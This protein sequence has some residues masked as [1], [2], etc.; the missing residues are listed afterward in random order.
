MSANI[1]F[2][3]VLGTALQP[4]PRPRICSRKP[5]AEWFGARKPCWQGFPHSRPSPIGLSVPLLL[6]PLVQRA[7]W[8]LLRELAPMFKTAKPTYSAEHQQWV[9]VILY[10]DNAYA[11][12]YA[13]S[14]DGAVIAAEELIALMKTAGYPKV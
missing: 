6:G 10:R 8:K 4:V 13:E 2:P 1:C 14:A 3:A 7:K 11:A 9:C 5:L 12:A